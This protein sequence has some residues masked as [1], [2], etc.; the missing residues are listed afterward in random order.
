LFELCHET[1]VKVFRENATTRG[2]RVARVE[3]NWS[4]DGRVVEFGGKRGGLELC[5]DQHRSKKNHFDFLIFAFLFHWKLAKI[6]FFSTL[7]T[8]DLGTSPS[9]T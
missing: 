3:F 6:C 2:H 1:F 9:F 5:V 8:I 7:S 4:L